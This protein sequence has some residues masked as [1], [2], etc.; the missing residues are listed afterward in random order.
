MDPIS[1]RDKLHHYID[2]ADEKKIQALYVILEAEIKSAYIFNEDEI[3]LFDERS[4]KRLSGESKTYTM[5][6][7]R[8]LISK[9]TS[10]KIE[11]I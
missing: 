7:T 1:I 4:H 2:V 5:E 11:P 8:N 10:K 3:K 9:N 6:E